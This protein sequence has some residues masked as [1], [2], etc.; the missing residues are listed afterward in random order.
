MHTWDTRRTR[1]VS[2][3]EGFFGAW[4]SVVFDMPATTT[5]Y[6]RVTNA[7]APVLTPALV[8]IAPA[9]KPLYGLVGK[10][11]LEYKPSRVCKPIVVFSS[12]TVENIETYKLVFAQYATAAQG[13][14]SGIRMLFSFLDTEKANTVLQLAWYDGPGDYVLPPPEL[15]K[16]Y[17]GSQ[18]TDYC[19]IW[20][21]WDDKFKR[22]LS[23]DSRVRCSFVK[24]TRGFLREANVD[25]AKGFATGEPPMIW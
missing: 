7:A 1:H 18:D 14:G 23:S 10:N 13:A 12:R 24:E 21:G 17:S 11:A 19:Q 16:L 9:I 8:G 3:L 2:V 15:T 22:A 4:P 20:G 25:N 6:D 5:W